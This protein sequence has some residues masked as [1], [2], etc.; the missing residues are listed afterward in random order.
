MVFNWRL[1]AS[2]E[3]VMKLMS[4]ILVII[5]T[6]VKRSMNK[7][8]DWVANEGIKIQSDRW[9][10]AWDPT[11]TNKMATTGQVLANNDWT[12]PY[13]V[14]GTR[15]NGVLGLGTKRMGETRGINAHT[16]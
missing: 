9:E 2:L 10:E 5:P 11:S 13:G 1:E 4:D 8:A 6:H 3:R 16:S 12:H 14:L 15:A 7:L